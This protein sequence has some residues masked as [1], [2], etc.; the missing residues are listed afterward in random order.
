MIEVWYPMK[1]IKNKMLKPSEV[2][3]FLQEL[4]AKNVAQATLIKKGGDNI[5]VVL[6]GDYFDVESWLDED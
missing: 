5:R 3:N 2:I 1:R 4:E 6:D